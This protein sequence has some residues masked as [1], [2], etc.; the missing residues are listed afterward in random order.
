[1]NAAYEWD[2]DWIAV[3]DD[4]EP[5]WLNRQ[6][7]NQELRRELCPGHVLYGVDADA[8]GKR[9]R[10]DDVLFLL[11]DGRVAE[12]HLTQKVETDPRWPWTERHPSFDAWKS[13]P[14]EDR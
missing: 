11:P 3:T 10:R 8:I 14:P 7:L 12:V 5:H 2:G 1:M 9:Q 4:A 13:V 6:W